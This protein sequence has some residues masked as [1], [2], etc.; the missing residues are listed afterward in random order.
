MRD[1][2]GLVDDTI[3]RISKRRVEFVWKS[4]THDIVDVGVQRAEMLICRG[5]VLVRCRCRRWPDTPTRPE[6]MRLFPPPRLVDY[7]APPRPTPEAQL[8]H[9]S[10]G[11]TAEMSFYFA[12]IG[13]KDNP[14][15]ECEFGTSKSGGDGVARVSSPIP[16]PGGVLT[17]VKFR[18]EQRPM[19]QFIL[20]SSLDIVEEVQWMQKELYLKTVDKFGGMMVSGFLTGGS[21]YWSPT[22]E[23]NSLIDNVMLIQRTDIKLLLLHDTKAEEAIRQ[24][25]AEVQEVYV[26]T[27]MNPFYSVDQRITSV[28]FDARVR[29]A[30]K[31][32]L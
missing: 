16:A 24:F 2:V 27:L 12:I 5:E 11:A 9:Q 18:E 17:T 4:V 21:A 25:F 19:N 10:S 13:T 7:P 1:I 22:C 30:A 20:H 26:K 23:L 6:P 29:A 14:I 3:P 31:K 15:Y 32:Y 8:K 28:V